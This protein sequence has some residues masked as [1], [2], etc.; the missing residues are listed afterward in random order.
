LDLRPDRPARGS[1]GGAACRRADAQTRRPVCGQVLIGKERND[2]GRPHDW[3]Y[4]VR[5]IVQED[6]LYLHN[7]KSMSAE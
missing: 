7:F 4:P 2:V 5:G 1:A 6:R 3:G